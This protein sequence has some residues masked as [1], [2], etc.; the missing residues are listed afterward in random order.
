MRRR[1]EAAPELL[2]HHDAVEQT[3]SGSAVLLRYE[4]AGETEAGQ[5]IP[6]LR[7]VADGIVLERADR[8]ERRLV[9]AE[10]ADG[11]AQHLLLLGE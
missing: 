4:G 7:A 5:L 9:V 2:V 3:H 8:L 10:A 11:L 1:C 6:E